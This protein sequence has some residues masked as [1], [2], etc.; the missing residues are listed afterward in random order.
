MSATRKPGRPAAAADPFVVIDRLEI[1]P[2][3][4]EP[5][6]VTAPYTVV[7]SGKRDS[8]DLV[9][10]FEEDVFDDGPGAR[11][12]AA[13]MA[14]QVALNY[15][16]FCKRLVFRGPYDEPDRKF[17]RR[18]AE[19][20]AREIYVNKFLMPNEFL[21]GA[22]RGLKAESRERYLRAEIEFEPD[23][24]GLTMRTAQL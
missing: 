15:G 2:V 14:A 17:L 24:L 6:R 3:R 4:V 23:R 1:G 5:R 16:L 11:N 22:M 20:T 21:V 18:F 10:R 12:V 13:M 7:R 19:N 9:Y 8:M